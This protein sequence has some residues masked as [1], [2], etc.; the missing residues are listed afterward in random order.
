[1]NTIPLTIVDDF[2]ENPYD[3][4]NWAL[5]V[6]YKK[7]PDPIFPGKRSLFLH[8]FQPYF[9]KYISK[10]ILSLFFNPIPTEINAQASFQIVDNFKGSGW[11]HQDPSTIT[12]ILYLSEI[13]NSLDGGTSLFNLKK[14]KHFSINNPQEEKI[15]ALRYKHYANNTLTNSEFDLKQKYE[16]NNFDKIISIPSKFN[17]LICFDGSHYHASNGSLDS[18]LKNRLTLIIFFTKMNPSSLYPVGRSKSIGMF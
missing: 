18:I 15:N 5:S 9:L 17:R 6:N 4:K 1:M 7:P 14:D 13:S 8:E 12:S 16:D 11:I 3:L 2:F 10:K